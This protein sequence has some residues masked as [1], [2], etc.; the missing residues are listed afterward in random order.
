MFIDDFE[1]YILKE[2]QAAQNT[3][4]AYIKDLEHF[5][6]FVLERGAKDLTD[7]SNTDIVSYVMEMKKEDKSRSTVNRKLTSIRT[8]YKFLVKEGKIK[9]NPAE[10][11]KSPRIEKKEI[12]YLSIDDV[13]KLMTL[14]DE[15]IK[16]KRDR[17]MLELMYATGIR[18]SELIDMKLDDCN[19]RMGFVKCSGEHSKARII[20]I[21]RPAR[22]ALETYIYDVRPA[23]LR[24]GDND[25]LFLNYVGEP[26]TR[27]GLWK[28]LKEYG[29]EA[30]FKIKLTPQVIRNSFAVHMLQNGADIKSIQELMGHEDIAA[31]QAYLAVTK[32]RIK[33]V[34]DRAHPRA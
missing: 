30:G 19:M 9:E 29:E 26:M 11:I 8:F 17:A 34:Y 14:P 18:A 28:I 15:T 5:E 3:V 20:P 6:T 24:G 21:G 16:G 7:V 31:T 23:M 22:M 2:K 32:N 13:D 25:S 1:K 12:E 27:Q 10:N 4:N 33:D